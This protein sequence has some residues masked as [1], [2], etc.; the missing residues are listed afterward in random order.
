[1]KLTSAELHPA[2]SSNVVVL[3]FRDPTR[4]NP[5][6]VKAIVGLDADEIIAR[7]YGGSGNSKRHTLSM[8]KRTIVIRIGLNPRVGEDETFSSLRDD[9]YKMIA[10]SRTGMLQLQLLNDGEAIAGISGFVTKVEAGLFNKEQE[11]QL[12]LECKDPELRGLTRTEVDVVDLDPALTVIEDT[13]STAPHGFIFELSFIDSV[14]SL[15]IEDP[16][17]SSWSFVVTP[18]GGF[19][20][21]DVLHYSSELNNKHLYV[22]R[23]ATTIHLADV[24]TPGSVWPILYPGENSLE[25]SSPTDVDWTSIEHYPTYWGV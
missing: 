14:A 5:Y 3:S 1:M 6:N 16:T 2:N 25:I 24:I 9:I 20:N 11:V 8:P 23:S 10:S 15:T 21:G 18:V 19:L 22:V 12:T 17:D 13:L 4:Q 7:Y